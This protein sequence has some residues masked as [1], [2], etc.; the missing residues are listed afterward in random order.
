MF[1]Y[2][3]LILGTCLAF[4][5]MQTRGEWSKNISVIG[6]LVWIVS[7]IYIFL[8]KGAKNG[9]LAILASFVVGA[10]CQRVFPKKYK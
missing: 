8:N 10:I 5:G 6:G 4:W 2:V 9:L 7:L 1:E 3:F